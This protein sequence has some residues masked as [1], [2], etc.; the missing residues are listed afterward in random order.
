MEK[1]YFTFGSGQTDEDGNSLYNYYLRI[2]ARSYLEARNKM[3]SLR[4]D[5]WSFQ[6]SE[7]EFAGQPEKYNLKI[8]TKKQVRLKK[9]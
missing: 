9:K 8:A 1:W 3:N 5:K 2:K 4:G 6:Y 7:Q